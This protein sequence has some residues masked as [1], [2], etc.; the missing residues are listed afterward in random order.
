MDKKTW[1]NALNAETKA[2]AEFAYQWAMTKS[3]DSLAF[4]GPEFLIACKARSKTKRANDNRKMRYDTM[5]SCGLTK[6][7]GA[8][9]GKVYWE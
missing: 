1:A 4:A 7:Y 8:V 5:R 2:N 9:S 6:V 3:K